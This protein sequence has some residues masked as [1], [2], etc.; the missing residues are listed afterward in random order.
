MNFEIRIKDI[1]SL[2][3]TEVTTIYNQLCHADSDSGSSM[4][5]ELEKRY[6]KPTPG[7]HP[8]MMLAMVWHNGIFV[9]WV[10]TRPWPEKFKGQPVTA[11]TVE[12]FTDLE[13]RR[14]GLARLGLQALISAGVLKRDKI[15]SAYSPAAVKLAQQCGC[16]TV[17]LCESA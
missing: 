17:I 9:S 1:N 12:C 2:S 14:H 11:Q 6:I 16:K 8:T 3:P 5:P 10:G 15:V 13:C 4:R 7:P